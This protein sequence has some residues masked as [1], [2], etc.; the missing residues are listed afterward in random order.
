MKTGTKILLIICFIAIIV[1]PLAFCE[2][3]YE[4]ADGNAAEQIEKTNPDYKPW[5]SNLYEPPSGEV[6]SLLF[7]LQAALGAGI[8]GYAAGYLKGKSKNNESNGCNC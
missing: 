4:G 6:E 1:F 5:F 2:G 7:A 3:S 8:L